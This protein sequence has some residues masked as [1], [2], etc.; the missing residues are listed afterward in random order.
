MI[1]K[2]FSYEEHFDC[3]STDSYDNVTLLVDLGP[4]K[5]GAKFE[6][7]DVNIGAG[8]VQFNNWDDSGFEIDV[9]VCDLA[10]QATNCRQIR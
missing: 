9:Y 1:R 3:G 2:I 7:A 8:W 6:Q 4:L 10:L 5:A